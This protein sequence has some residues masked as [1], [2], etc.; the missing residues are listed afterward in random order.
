VTAPASSGGLI[1][2]S[3]KYKLDLAILN[4]IRECVIFFIIAGR[5]EDKFLFGGLGVILKSIAIFNV[6][7]GNVFLAQAEKKDYT[8]ELI[9]KEEWC[10]GCGICVAF[11]PREALF[12]DEKSKAQEDM[13]KCTKCG[14]CETFCPD[15]A[16]SLIKRRLYI[17]A[18]D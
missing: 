18:G 15:F 9:I 7:G 14:I 6:K 10:K 13:E 8:A 2:I 1:I 11:C 4:I 17:N 16:I 12:L 5:L 3:E